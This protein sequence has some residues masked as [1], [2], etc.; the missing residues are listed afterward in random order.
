MVNPDRT[1]ESILRT[2][3]MTRIGERHYRSQSSPHVQNVEY[4]EA[5]PNSD[6]A[7]HTISARQRDTGQKKKKREE[8]KIKRE[9]H[10]RA[11]ARVHTPTHTHASNIR[12]PRAS[13]SFSLFFFFLFFSKIRLPSATFLLRQYRLLSIYL[14]WL[15]VVSFIRFR[16]FSY[17][18]VLTPA[19]AIAARRRRRRIARQLGRSAGS[20]IVAAAKLETAGY[21]QQIA[22]AYRARIT[23][24]YAAAFPLSV[25]RAA[26]RETSHTCAEEEKLRDNARIHRSRM[27]GSRSR[28]L[29]GACDSTF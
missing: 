4:T 26:R 20:L 24:N 16:K 11:R 13:V 19:G 7:T 18:L 1:L 10:T 12:F 28:W 27:P 6:I 17:R 25:R 2:H 8:K 3:D 15:A 5:Y 21:T 23:F 9:I 14:L 22:G 29:F